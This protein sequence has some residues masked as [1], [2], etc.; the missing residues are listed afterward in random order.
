MRKFILLIPLILTCFTFIY[1]LNGSNNVWDN[2]LFELN[3]F[4][5]QRVGDN[6]Y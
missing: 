4:V 2:S 6:N 3:I 5:E 1:A